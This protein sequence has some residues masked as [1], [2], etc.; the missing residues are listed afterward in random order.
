MLTACSSSVVAAERRTGEVVGRTCALP[1]TRIASTPLR[2]KRPVWKIVPSSITTEEGP[3]IIVVE[4]L[5]LLGGEETV[6][7]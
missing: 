4:D 2:G 1:V 5:R 3:N 7:G 6:P